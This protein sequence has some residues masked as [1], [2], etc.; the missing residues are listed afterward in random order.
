M[1]YKLIR[2]F[3]YNF[4]YKI[5]INVGLKFYFKLHKQETVDYYKNLL[6][7]VMPHNNKYFSNI[8]KRKE[9][10]NKKFEIRLPINF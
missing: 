4:L 1:I 2:Y 7:V 8:N 5:W 10:N 3:I 9:N 6:N